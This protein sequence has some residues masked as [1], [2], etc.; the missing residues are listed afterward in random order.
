MFSSRA[1]ELI[2]SLEI[3]NKARKSV[4]TNTDEFGWLKNVTE[5]KKS[6]MDTTV[7]SSTTTNSYVTPREE[8]SP[9]NIGFILDDSL[10]N[11]TILSRRRKTFETVPESP[12]SIGFVLDNLDE[13]N[14]C[15]RGSSLF[16][17]IESD[18]EVSKSNSLPKDVKI[19]AENLI[20]EDESSQDSSSR[21]KQLPKLSSSGSLS[22]YVSCVEGNTRDF[23]SS[24]CFESCC[25]KN[26]TFDD[27][28]H[29]RNS[30]RLSVSSKVASTVL[31]DIL[32][33]IRGNEKTPVNSNV[34]TSTPEIKC[35]YCNKVSLC[36]L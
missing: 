31:D 7:G 15:T 29:R 17:D 36:T 13:T 27:R 28:C 25:E 1:S 12:P 22:P 16:S 33:N 18:L 8:G 10:T 14:P 26:S 5:R 19:G 11:S 6:P 30:S 21:E 20:T 32:R 9:P 4:T 2:E 23:K 34:V 35:K 3:A 24:E